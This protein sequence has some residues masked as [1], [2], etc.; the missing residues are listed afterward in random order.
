[1]V[2][3]LAPALPEILPQRGEVIAYDEAAG[4]GTI[5]GVDGREWWFHCTAIA[6]GSRQIDV[7][8]VGTFTLVAGRFGRWEAMGI[9]TA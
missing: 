7:G 1:M 4:Y 6:D 2:D 8:A 3:P 9:V 5:R